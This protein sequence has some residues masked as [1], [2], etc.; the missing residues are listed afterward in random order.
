[1]PEIANPLIQEKRENKVIPGGQKLHDYANLYFH[2]RNPMM[3]AIQHRREELCVLRIDKRILQIDGAIIADGNA[4]SNYTK[5]SDVSSGLAEL[6]CDLVFIRDW[7][8]DNRITYYRQKRI[9]CA[10][11]LIPKVAPRGY[12]L[13]AYVFSDTAQQ[14]L[15]A[16]TPNLAIDIDRDLFT[17]VPSQNIGGMRV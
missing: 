7:R 14:K 17:M 9:R 15:R 2:A 10:E 11:A 5:F 16:L 1:M 8:S 6:D 13:G 3:C 12:I 4:S